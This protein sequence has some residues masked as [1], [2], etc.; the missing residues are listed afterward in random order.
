MIIIHGGINPG[1]FWRLSWY[2]YLLLL[3]RVREKFE[4]ENRKFSRDQSIARQ[5]YAVLWNA[6]RDP[7]KPARSP[8]MLWPMESDKDA[9]IEKGRRMK[10]I[11]SRNYDN[12]KVTWRSR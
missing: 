11:L 2:D 6:N 5:I 10:E 4:A 3:E 1:E 9:A 7:K 12:L 8:E